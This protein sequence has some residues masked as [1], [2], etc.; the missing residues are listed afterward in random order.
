MVKIVVIDWRLLVVV[1]K[2]VEMVMQI[3]DLSR[4]CRVMSME[5]VCM[6]Q[7]VVVHMA[8]ML[9]EVAVVVVE[10]MVV[11]LIVDSHYYAVALLQHVVE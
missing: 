8:H 1:L 10:Y 2:I 7:L 4:A 11:E 5:Q 6:R 3:V 9:V